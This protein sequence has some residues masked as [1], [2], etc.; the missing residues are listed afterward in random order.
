MANWKQL[1]IACLAGALICGGGLG[2]W[3]YQALHGL[4]TRN[5]LLEIKLR[6]LGVRLQQ[7]TDSA[8]AL[9]TEI[10]TLKNRRDQGYDQTIDALMQARSV[11]DV[12]ALYEIGL[13]ALQEKDY[14]RAYFSLAQVAEARADYK[15]IAK[16]LP[17]AK[18]AY[19]QFQHSQQ[20]NSLAQDYAL[21]L[22]HQRKGEIAQAV[23]AFQRVVKIKPDYRDAG[24]RL[25]RLGQLLAAVQGARD[26]AQK[27]QWLEASYQ[28]GVKQQG[29]GRYA[30]AREVYAQ[31]VQD[32]PGYRD[33]AQRLRTV[34]ALLPKVQAVSQ[35][36]D[37]LCY[38]LGVAFGNCAKNPGG[39]NCARFDTGH[40]PAICKDNPA[41]RKGLASLMAAE[42]GGDPAAGADSRLTQQ[43][44]LSMLKD[45][46]SVLGNL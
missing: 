2:A 5:Q 44:A 35:S 20:E 36:P 18:Q 28:L 24:L 4:N 29:L 38:Q 17:Q 37:E 11:A 23:A 33:T 25:R 14:P 40:A 10:D 8:S 7:Q 19:Q 22:D 1:L 6:A 34:T 42:T 43:K 15:Q 45:L 30:A 27:R 46:P 16:L 12:D 9:Q 3:A 31:I 21:G 26:L 41:F 13:K 32:A 39:P